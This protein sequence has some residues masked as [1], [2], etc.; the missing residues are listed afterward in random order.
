MDAYMEIIFDKIAGDIMRGNA[1]GKMKMDIDT[2]GNFEM[3]GDVEIVKGAYNFTFLNVVNKEFGVKKGSKIS[4][5]GD[6]YH[7]D[8]D[9]V[10]TYSQLASFAPILQVDSVVANSAELKRRYPVQ[11]NLLLNGD[12]MTPDIGF[13]IEFSDY[14]PVVVAAGQAISIEGQ[15]ARFRRQIAN[16]PQELNRQ[17]FSLIVLKK[18]SAENAFDGINQSAGNSVSELLSNQLSYWA[19]QVDDNFEVNLDLGGLSQDD[20]NALQLRLSYSFLD[21][22][23]RVTRD[24]GFTNVQNETNVASI[25]GNW[26]VEY[27]IS[28]DGRLRA[29]AFHRSNS[30]TF[31]STLGNASSTGAGFLYTISFDHFKD[32]LNNARKKQQKVQQTKTIE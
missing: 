4:W 9:L 25:A 27:I 1:R 31:N 26:T 21:G 19:S 18:F 22:R 17:A 3:F 11:V 2:D 20:F 8:L 16:N 30:N 28:K 29:K 32:I 15:L 14:P 13:D 7:A 5:S 10:A 24:G 12:L 23:V 6:P